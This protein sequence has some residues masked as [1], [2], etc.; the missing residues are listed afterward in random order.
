MRSSLRSGTWPAT[1]GRRKVTEAGRGSL[2]PKTLNLALL[3]PQLPMVRFPSGVEHQLMPLTAESYELWLEVQQLVRSSEENEPIDVSY[4]HAL[5]DLLL[6]KV[7]PTASKDDLASLGTRTEVKLA[8]CMAAAG[9]IDSVMAALDALE[10]NVS[11]GQNTSR[12]GPRTTSERRSRGTP[13]R[14]RKT[15]GTST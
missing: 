14:T 11:A 8:P 7:L 13:S 2:K 1:S 4:F 9:Q 5:L 12:S 6:A 15:G 3:V 10:G